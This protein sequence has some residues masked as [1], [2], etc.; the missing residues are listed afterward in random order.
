MKSIFGIDLVPASNRITPPKRQLYR[1]GGWAMRTDDA[2]AWAARLTRTQP[3][4]LDAPA[5]LAVLRRHLNTRG[6]QVS[7][8]VDR[9][10]GKCVMVVCHREMWMGWRSGDDGSNL[11]GWILGEL[12]RMALDDIGREYLV[13][14]L[15]HSNERLSLSQQDVLYR[16]IDQ[17]ESEIVKSNR[18]LFCLQLE[19]Q[20]SIQ[21]MKL[22]ERDKLAA[23]TKLSAYT[24]LLAPV[25]LLPLE[26]LGMIFV[27]SISHTRPDTYG[28]S[29]LALS[30]VCSAWRAAL[31]CP[32]IWTSLELIASNQGTLLG[33]FRPPGSTN[34]CG[35]I[36]STWFSRAGSVLPL[37][38]S[39]KLRPEAFDSVGAP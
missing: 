18:D 22:R 38:L 13:D 15:A 12:G 27:H 24:A 30:H 26:V 21:K 36:L 32:E 17:Q 3:E 23:L 11:K 20:V 31:A 14:T 19:A 34:I 28:T 35:T 2:R 8:V 16:L 1:L 7:E 5:V 9:R 39:L 29:A 33:L 6:L 37:S 4:T 25:R 10:L